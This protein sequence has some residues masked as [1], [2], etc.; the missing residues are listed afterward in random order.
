M[1]NER[2]ND[3]PIRSWFA[4][5]NNPSDHGYEGPP[6]EVIERLR[7]EWVEGHPTRTGAWAYCVSAD[8]LHHVHMVL[9]DTKTMRFSVVKKEYAQGMHF[10]PTRGSKDQAEDYIHKRGKWEEKGEQILAFCQH[11]EIKG[12]QGSRRDIFAIDDMIQSGM[13]PKQI[14][15]QNIAFRRYEK[16]IKDAYFQKLEDETPPLRDVKVVWHVGFAGSGKTYSYIKL[17]EQNPDQ[18]YLVSD[19]DNSMLDDYCGEKIL[20]LDEFRG[21]IRYSKLLAMLQGYR[22]RFHARYANITGYWT[23]VHISS[24]MPPEMVYKNMVEEH[25]EID[26]IKQL[27]R[28]IGTIVYHWHDST[29]YHEFELPFEQYKSLGDLQK[30]AT[31]EDFVEL[32]DYEYLGECPFT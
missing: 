19:Y 22:Q 27:Y 11:G 31:K 17:L 5:F 2:E 32:E 13:T 29:G 28:R 10:E 9:E 30:M 15:R 16:M 18:V 6:E 4:V 3:Q 8:G 14:M 24:V 23:E 1:K 26:T 25:R 7:S 21:Q 20:F 12:A